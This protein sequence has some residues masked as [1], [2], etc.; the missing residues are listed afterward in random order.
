MTAPFDPRVGR[1]RHLTGF[2]RIA[3]VVVLAA[4]G[5]G[6]LLPPDPGRSAA[7]VMVG[8]L[9][10]IP[11]IRLLWLALRW[12]HKGDRRFAALALLLVLLVGV[13]ALLGGR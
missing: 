5:L 12:L 8:L 10:A 7:T 2:L 11:L 3:T 4:A 1:Q 6:V 9:I 13:G